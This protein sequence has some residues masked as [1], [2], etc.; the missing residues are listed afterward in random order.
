MK[1]LIVLCAALVTGIVCL[2]SQ[3]FA[4]KKVSHTDFAGMKIDECNTCH[5]AEGVAPNHGADFVRNHRVLAN[6]PGN[7]CQQ[8]HTQ[9]FCLDCH[10]GGGSGSNLKQSTFGRDYKP[11]DHDG[12]FLDRHGRLSK[13][14]PQNCVRCHAQKYCSD[15]HSRYPQGTLTIK[16]HR[17]LGANNQQYYAP[18]WAI[19]HSAEARR[20]LQ[21]CQAC[22]ASGDVCIQCHSSG[23]TNPHPRGWKGISNTYKDKSNGKTCVKCHLPGTF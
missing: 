3:S 17:K 4:S 16:S 23:R 18:N 12:N 2:Y 7:N 11:L 6:N 20:N 15:C 1:K 14:N 5:K 19:D 13:N 21:S 10:Q 9:S 8:C 22:H